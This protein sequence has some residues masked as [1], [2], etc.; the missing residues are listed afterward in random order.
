[1]QYRLLKA[2]EL[3]GG[4]RLLGEA[5]RG[6]TAVCVRGA[7]E[8]GDAIVLPPQNSGPYPTLCLEESELLDEDHWSLILQAAEPH[9]LQAARYLARHP[10]L[11]A[12][13]F[14][15]HYGFA[16][17]FK[18]L[19]EWKELAEFDDLTLDLSRGYEPSTAVLRLWNRLPQEQR[20]EWLALFERRRF[21]RNLVREIVV[22]LYDLTED[23]RLLALRQAVELDQNWRAHSQP[24]P[25]HRVRDR[26]RELRFPRLSAAREQALRIK[27][28]LPALAGL[29]VEL[30]PDLEQ[31]GIALSYTIEKTGDL[32]RLQQHLDRPEV[33]KTLGELLSLL[34]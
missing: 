26:L 28:R 20:R 5:L 6:R 14:L 17:N 4:H 18:T 9:R 13:P 30:P 1:M 32:E 10:D 24:F 12:G 11:P 23:D 31:G 3:T 33:Q 19:S 27:R 29:R 16:A 8:P 21:R 15:A 22:D 2:D 34:D 7:E 25:A